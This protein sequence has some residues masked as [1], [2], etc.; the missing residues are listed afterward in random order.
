MYLVIKALKSRNCNKCLIL[1][2]NI[3][4]FKHKGGQYNAFAHLQLWLS[5]VSAFGFLSEGFVH[6]IRVHL[7]PIN[8]QR[9]YE[10]ITR[11]TTATKKKL[12]FLRLAHLFIEHHLTFKQLANMPCLLA[13]QINQLMLCC[14]IYNNADVNISNVQAQKFFLLQK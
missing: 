4:K 14:S 5:F 3:L 8:F 11:N 1:N 9:S 7:S 12:K 10:P 2:E 13:N 6:V